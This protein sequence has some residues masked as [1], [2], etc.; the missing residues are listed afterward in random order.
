MS[1]SNNNNSSFYIEKAIQ[2]E[3][4]T[5]CQAKGNRNNTLNT[6]A[7]KLFGFVKAGA[8][9][10]TWIEDQLTNA[11]LTIGLDRHEIRDTLK[12][13]YSGA[14]PRRLPDSLAPGQPNAPKVDP[15][16]RDEAKP[17]NDTWQARALRIVERAAELLWSKAGEKAREY[18]YRRGLSDDTIRAF[19]LG[20][21][22][23]DI[24]EEPDKWGLD[25]GKKVF[26]PRGI[27]IPW[28][29][30]GDVWRLQIRKPVARSSGEK[31][32]VFVRSD[33][34]CGN[35]LYNADALMPGC[36]AVMVEGTF[37][38]MAVHQAAGDLVAP[39]A[40]GSSMARR[41]R[42]IVQLAQC[43]EV[44]LAFDADAG[45]EGAIPYWRDVFGDTAKVWQP[46]GDDPSAMLQQGMGVREWICA[47]LD[48]ECAPHIREY[49]MV[50]LRALWAK[51]RR[52]GIP[53]PPGEYTN[54]ADI[55]ARVT[56]W[57]GVVKVAAQAQDI[58]WDTPRNPDAGAVRVSPIA[59]AQRIRE[60]DQWQS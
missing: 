48:I 3:L 22:P 56:H 27:V 51:A 55:A 46:Y 2:E 28:P 52:L 35:A 25:G 33:E 32:Y 36:P 50:D 30:G 29:V 9:D 53:I 59:A 6:V 10:Q 31:V 38:A 20:Y 15:V 21:C 34:G 37:D 54:T 24:W 12:S 14:T 1:L 8:V 18:L 60:V 23:D 17:P 11:A 39:V 49:R 19:E 4:D 57:R 16:P 13:A 44:L 43:S 40:A 42:W 47:G 58:D 45:G 41:M 26:L 7:L 5:L